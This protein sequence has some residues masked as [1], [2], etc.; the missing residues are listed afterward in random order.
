MNPLMSA[1]KAPLEDEFAEWLLRRKLLSRS[2]VE[3]HITRL[4]R[5]VADYG[6]RG[7]LTAATA[8]KRIRQTQIYYKE[9]ICEYYIPLLLPLLQSDFGDENRKP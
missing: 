8:D 9:F 7:F 6:I 4:R 3:T 5:A 1:E 2:T